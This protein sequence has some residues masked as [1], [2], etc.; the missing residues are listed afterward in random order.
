MPR[1]KKTEPPRQPAVVAPAPAMVPM[2]MQPP[3]QMVP[4]PIQQQPLAAGPVQPP[5]TIGIEEFIRVRDSVSLINPHHSP[6]LLSTASITIAIITI[7]NTIIN[8]TY[9]PRYSYDDFD[10]RR[11]CPS[12]MLS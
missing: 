11:P 12:T 8:L 1:P 9:I 5:R 6:P 7:A 2:A 4:Q 10:R 3:P